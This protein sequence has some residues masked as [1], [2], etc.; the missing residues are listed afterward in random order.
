M[1]CSRCG[2]TINEKANF[3]QACGEKL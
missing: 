2:E 1:N 3:C